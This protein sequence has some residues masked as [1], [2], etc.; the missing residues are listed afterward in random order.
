MW[1]FFFVTNWPQVVPFIVGSLRRLFNRK[2][3]PKPRSRL[4][5]GLSQA[6]RQTLN[7]SWTRAPTLAEIAEAFLLHSSSSSSSFISRESSRSSLWPHI[8]TDSSFLLMCVCSRLNSTDRRSP[9]FLAKDLKSGQLFTSVIYL[10][11]FCFLKF[12]GSL[13]W[14]SCISGQHFVV[15]CLFLAYI[16]YFK[17]VHSC[18]TPNL[19]FFIVYLVFSPSWRLI[20]S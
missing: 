20:W 15:L 14:Q 13:F 7:M 8:Q 19:S 18:L 17:C 6:R 11:L 10:R 12:S 1:T 9:V 2:Q 16:V 5:R 4:K 3:T